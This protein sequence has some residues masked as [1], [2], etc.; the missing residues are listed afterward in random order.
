MAVYMIQA[1]PFGDIKIGFANDPIAR[2]R[3]LQTSM[4]H[5]LRL[6]RVFEGTMD[7]EKEL[8]RKFATARKAGEWF[9]PSAEMLSGDVGLN[10]LPLPKRKRGVNCDESTALGRYRMVLDDLLE[11]IGGHTELA[12]AL[13]VAPW[14]ADRSIVHDAHVSA[15]IVLA[16][17]R[18]AKVTLRHVFSLREAWVRE[19]REIERAKEDAETAWV[20]KPS[21]SDRAAELDWIEANGEASV[22]WDRFSD[23]PSDDDG[24]N[25]HAA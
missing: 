24:G 23:Q 7:D 16:R 21:E 9:S 6:V 10:E 3:Q 13:G 1:G 19:Q 25:D 12:K 18:G 15:L 5:K 22:W 4:P 8:H 11:F 17:Q 20:A 2:M 14:L